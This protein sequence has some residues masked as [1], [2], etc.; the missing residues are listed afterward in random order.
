[1][2]P[3]LIESTQSSSW[4]GQPDPWLTTQSYKGRML[5]APIS[6]FTAKLSKVILGAFQPSQNYW[7]HLLRYKTP[8]FPIWVNKNTRGLTTKFAKCEP[9]PDSIQ[10]V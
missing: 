2:G 3:T 4:T 7:Y 9:H 8:G 1:M 10:V 6:R 5:T